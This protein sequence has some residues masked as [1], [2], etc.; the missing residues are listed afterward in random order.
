MV[1]FEREDTISSYIYERYRDILPPIG[2]LLEG[3]YGIFLQM[4]GEGPH[5]VSFK[6]E[7]SQDTVSSSLPIYM[8]GEGRLPPF[9]WVVKAHST[10]I[11][12]RETSPPNRE[13]FAAFILR[14]EAPPLPVYVPKFTHHHL[15]FFILDE[16]VFTPLQDFTKTRRESE[17]KDPFPEVHSVFFCNCIVFFKLDPLIFRDDVK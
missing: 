10:F 1:S 16:E 4:R 3:R 13:K 9:M 15:L 17:K 12:G 6:R 8:R 2:V 14:S 5:L 11:L 7:D